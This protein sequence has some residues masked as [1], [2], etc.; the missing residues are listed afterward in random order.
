MSCNS[1][2]A[3]DSHS[4]SDMNFI[5]G[6]VMEVED[7]ANMSST[8]AF[9]NDHE[10]VFKPCQDKPMADVD[11]IAK[12]NEQRW[13]EED[14]LQMQQIRLEGRDKVE[15]R[16]SLTACAIVYY[17]LPTTGVFSKFVSCVCIYGFNLV[18]R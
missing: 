13:P 16:V 7:D 10:W 14:K 9:I 18:F 5:R 4:Y 15:S 11:W 17:C 12:Y 8:D 2:N 3:D 6:Y 1:S